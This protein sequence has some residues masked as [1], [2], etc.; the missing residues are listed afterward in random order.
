MFANLSK[1]FDASRRS[2][3]VEVGRP[4]LTA[5]LAPLKPNM[6]SPSGSSIVARRAITSGYEISLSPSTSYDAHRSRNSFGG[7]MM[8]RSR[9]TCRKSPYE[10]VPSPL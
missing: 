9:S 5:P 10:S 2:A 7:N 4:F 6:L 3:P 8:P 1:S